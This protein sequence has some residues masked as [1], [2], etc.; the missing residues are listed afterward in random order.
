MGALVGRC[1]RCHARSFP[2]SARPLRW[3]ALDFGRAGAVSVGGRRGRRCG[4]LLQ[5]IRAFR[6]EG[7]G[8]G[9]H[10][11]VNHGSHLFPSNRT[12]HFGHRTILK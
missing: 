1:S 4:H 10:V 5:I 7:G 2:G 11:N 8:I 12:G 6:S 9:P 3:R